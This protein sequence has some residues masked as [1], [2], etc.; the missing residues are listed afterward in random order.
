[1]R[2]QPQRFAAGGPSA[3]GGGIDSR[4]GKALGWNP[5]KSRNVGG[6]NFLATRH[7][8]WVV[9]DGRKFGDEVH[10]DIAFLPE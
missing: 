10:E 9:S 3:H 2:G 1:M 4:T 5:T 7:G 8:L 6:R